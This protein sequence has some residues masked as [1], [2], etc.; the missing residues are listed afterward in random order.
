MARIPSLVVV[1]LAGIGF[2]NA[3][4]SLASWHP[5]AP[6]ECTFAV[7]PTTYHSYD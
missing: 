7:F 1:G 5:A 3:Q 6:G 4:G 2:V